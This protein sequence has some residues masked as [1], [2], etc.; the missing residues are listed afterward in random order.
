MIDWTENGNWSSVNAYVHSD[1]GWFHVYAF[2]MTIGM[3]VAIAASGFIFWRRKIPIDGLFYGAIVIIPVSLFG[4][5]FF[6]KLN[7]EA[8]GVNANGV[9]FWGLFAFW[10]SG[11]AIHGGVYCGSTVGMI[12]FYFIGRKPRVSLWTYMDAIIPNILLGQAIGRWGNFFNAEVTGAPVGNITSGTGNF[13]KWLPDFITD[14]TQAIYHGEQTIINGITYG[15]GDIAQMS[16]IFIYESF[17]LTI[18][19]IIIYFVMPGFGKWISKK[20]WKLYPDNFKINVR[21]SFLYFFTRKNQYKENSYIDIWNKAYYTKYDFELSK[22]YSE[23]INFFLMNKKNKTELVKVFGTTNIITIK[24]NLGK[25]LNKINNPDKY[26]MTKSGSQAGAY[27]FAWNI[28]RFVLELQRPDDH[29]FIMFQKTLSLAIIFLTAM[30]GLA[31]II[32]VNTFVPYLFRKENFL[33]E[34]EFISNN[35]N[36]QV[37]KM[38]NVI[39]KSDKQLIAEQKAK[40]KLEKL[41]KK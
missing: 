19:W 3:L 31:L 38:K 41:K 34:K 12:I 18:S 20:P 23:K 2:T 6:G 28:V 11:M 21:N 37:K 7:A 22:E 17:W 35:T 33:Y 14:N 9:G 13:L 27:F 16:P 40:Q 39:K 8:P 4:A 10:N 30:I 36:D 1:Y 26:L 15:S 24:W 29:L 25:M 32:S 5:S